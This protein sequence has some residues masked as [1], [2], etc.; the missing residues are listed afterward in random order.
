MYES[1]YLSKQGK[2]FE[3]GGQL[4]LEFQDIAII[5]HLSSFYLAVRKY[6]EE[7]FESMKIM[8]KQPHLVIY[9]DVPVSIV[10]KRIKERN[11]SME[12]NTSVLTEK[13]LTTIDKSYKQK[14]LKNMRSVKYA[15][16]IVIL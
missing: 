7:Q 5:I 3:T 8:L 15:L 14:F 11:R 1:G 13:Y 6:Y 4:I 16:M 10:Q 9:L 2:Q 12:T